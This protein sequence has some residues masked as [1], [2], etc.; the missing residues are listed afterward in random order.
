MLPI[1]L[2]ESL[3]GVL[4]FSLLILV[5]LGYG[6]HIGR[7]LWSKLANAMILLF[8]RLLAADDV[9]IHWVSSSRWKHGQR[10]FKKTTVV[11]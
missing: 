3:T 6:F 7:S 9:P 2:L 4:I 5:G 1:C 10:T 8:L 11:T